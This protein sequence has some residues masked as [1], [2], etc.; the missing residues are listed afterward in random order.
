LLGIE[1]V[2]FAR[3]VRGHGRRQYRAVLAVCR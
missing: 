2:F 3:L 1:A